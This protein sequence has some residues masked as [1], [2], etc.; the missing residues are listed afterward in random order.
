MCLSSFVKYMLL[1]VIV[2]TLVIFAIFFENIYYFIPAM[3]AAIIQSKMVCSK[4]KTPILKD[5]N[6]WY[7]F[8]VRPKCRTCGHDTMICSEKKK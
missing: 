1:S 4:C 2:G 8:T 5:K 3:V 6:G 7:I